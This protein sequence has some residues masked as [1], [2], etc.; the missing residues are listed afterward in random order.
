MVQRQ[1][2]A[3]AGHRATNANRARHSPSAEVIS[4]AMT[5]LKNRHRRKAPKDNEQSPPGDHRQAAGCS[6]Q[7]KGGCEQSNEREPKRQA[8]RVAYEQTSPW[9]DH[10]ERSAG[11]DEQR[12]EKPK[13]HIEQTAVRICK[14]RTHNG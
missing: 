9:V 3:A 8:R 6:S 7:N 1:N 12:L 10:G 5:E 4:L 14:A 13:Q 11:G 2:S